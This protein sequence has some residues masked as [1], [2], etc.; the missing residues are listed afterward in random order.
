MYFKKN[1]LFIVPTKCLVNITQD[2]KLKIK[3]EKQ[4]AVVVLGNITTIL[5]NI[6]SRSFLKLPPKQIIQIYVHV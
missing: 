5:V 4:K 6:I 3:I 1:Q 2:I